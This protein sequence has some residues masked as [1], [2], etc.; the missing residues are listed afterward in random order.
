MALLHAIKLNVGYYTRKKCFPENAMV[1]HRT[2]LSKGA[3]QRKN[4]S[5]KERKKIQTI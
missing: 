5:K 4:K 3:L 1:F 2:D